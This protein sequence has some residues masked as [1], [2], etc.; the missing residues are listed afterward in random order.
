[1]TLATIRSALNTALTSVS[2]LRVYDKAVETP[3]E[4]PYVVVLADKGNYIYDAAG[5]SIHFM[6]LLLIVSK[7]GSLVEA[8]TSLDS[9]I[10]ESGTTSVYAAVK[11]TVLSGHY[12]KLG[13]Y[14]DV[15]AHRWS[16]QEYWGC[17]FDL[18]VGVKYLGQNAVFKLDCHVSLLQDYYNT[19]DDSNDA[20]HGVYWS[21]QSFTALE[22]YTLSSVKLKLL[23]VGSPGTIQI[24]LYAVDGSGKPTG[25]AL[26]TG[27]YNGNLLTTNSN[28][29]WISI[30]LSA[31]SIVATTQYVI[32]INAIGGDL[33]NLVGIREDITS[34]TYTGGVEIVSSNSGVSWSLR[35]DIDLMFEIWGI[36]TS[37]VDLS[38]WLMTFKPDFGRQF[39]KVLGFGSTQMIWWPTA[40]SCKFSADFVFDIAAG[41]AWDVMKDWQ[42]DVTTRTW[43]YGPLGDD[44]GMPKLTGE[45]WIKNVNIPLRVEEKIVLPVDF[46]L[47]GALTITTY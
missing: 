36:P 29:T 21:A 5:D 46:I 8:Q 15:G 42:D 45:C 35:P 13:A 22:S 14:H 27:T 30:S 20:V 43:E 3:N 23:R 25:T 31:Y 19:N 32:V 4:P 40:D 28:G 2:G 44:T 16:G 47:N 24:G 38:P 12:F 33:F 1:M 6:K 34:P 37:V 9:Y 7:A 39:N 18:E 11:A 10:D 26:S 17:V 41:S